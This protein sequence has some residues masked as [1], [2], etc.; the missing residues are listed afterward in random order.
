MMGMAKVDIVNETLERVKRSHSCSA[1][2]AEGEEC[3]FCAL[4]NLYQGL[5][6][7]CAVRDAEV[8]GLSKDLDFA[9]RERAKYWKLLRADYREIVTRAEQAEATVGRVRKVP[10]EC[11]MVMCVCC[12]KIVI[13]ECFRRCTREAHL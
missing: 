11:R 9:E 5:Q 12:F 1:L 3:D 4:L 10:E 7:N 6:L 13:T 2:H 8:V